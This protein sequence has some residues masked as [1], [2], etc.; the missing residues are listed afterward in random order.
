MEHL[1]ASTSPIPFSGEDWFD[2][3]EDA[4]RFHRGGP[5]SLDGLAAIVR[6]DP[7]M[8]FMPPAFLA[9]SPGHA[10]EMARRAHYRH[11]PA[12]VH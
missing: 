4:I 6:W 8:I 11:S 5:Q 7:M 2:P 12:F 1:T 3:L 9:P 10:P